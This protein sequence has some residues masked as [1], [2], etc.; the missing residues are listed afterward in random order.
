MTRMMYVPICNWFHAKRANSGKITYRGQLSLMLGVGTWTASLQLMLKISY[1]NFL[2]ISPAILTQ[3]NL[4]MCAAA[5]DCEKFVKN[6]FRGFK[7][8]QSHRR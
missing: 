5:N 3:F 1:A 8:V 4:K 7:V 6:P 2:G